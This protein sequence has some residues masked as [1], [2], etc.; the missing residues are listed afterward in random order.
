MG[1]T[2]A[3]PQPARPWSHHHNLL[4]AEL[5]AHARARRAERHGGGACGW[6]AGEG[7]PRRL[8]PRGRERRRGRRARAPCVHGTAGAFT[9]RAPVGERECSARGL[10]S[11]R[12]AQPA[13]STL[14]PGRACSAHGRG[15]RFAGNPRSGG[16][17]RTSRSSLRSIVCSRSAMRLPPTHNCNSYFL[18]IGSSTHR[19]TEDLTLLTTSIGIPTFTFCSI[20]RMDDDD[21]G[22]TGRR[23]ADGRRM[24]ARHFFSAGT[25]AVGSTGVGNY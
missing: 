4:A 10:T 3:R 15:R 6:R 25:D 18:S 20:S 11:W 12:I 22:V 1:R 7:A 17:A 13:G 24:L 19:S 21:A 8:R 2:G 14:H 23:D 16:R 5:T 9:C